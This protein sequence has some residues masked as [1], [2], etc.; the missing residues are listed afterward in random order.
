MPPPTARKPFAMV[1]PN[2]LKLPLKLTDLKVLVALSLHADWT[3]TGNG[4]CFPKR[5]TI[6]RECNVE[7]S[8]VS[9]AL[10]R[11]EKLGLLHTAR[12]GRKNVYFVRPI[13]TEFHMPPSNAEPYFAFLAANGHEFIVDDGGVFKQV[14]GDLARLHPFYTSIVTE[15]VNGL[16][17]ARLKTATLARY[18]NDAAAA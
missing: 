13:G 1:D 9:E 5:E 18:V 2:W 12:L 7:V 17:H 6:A 8:H 4:R 3:R 15:Y 11:L 14:K 16:P 10:P